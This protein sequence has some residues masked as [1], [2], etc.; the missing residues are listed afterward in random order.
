[1]TSVSQHN[2]STAFWH[3]DSIYS[4]V[5][6]WNIAAIHYKECVTKNQLKS[7]HSKASKL[8][9]KRPQIIIGNIWL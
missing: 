6:H 4:H 7:N 9:A 5:K 2:P 3:S 1:M 8:S